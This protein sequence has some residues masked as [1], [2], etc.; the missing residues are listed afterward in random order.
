MPRR[1]RKLVRLSSIC[2]LALVALV[3]MSGMSIAARLPDKNS[4]IL[5]ASMRALERYRSTGSLSDLQSS[6]NSLGVDMSVIK[7]NE[8]VA[9]RRALIGAWARIIRTIDTS[10]D[11]KY[12]PSDANERGS[13]CLVPPREASGVQRP[14]CAD[15][16]A[17][18][19]P[20]AREKYIAELRANASKIK[21]TNF[22]Y[23]LKNIDSAAM[24]SLQMQLR[25]FR[26]AH[27]PD[28]FSALDSILRKAG[29]SDTRRAAI[30]AM[31]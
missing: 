14:S 20:E 3:M 25:G 18:Q 27:A 1:E 23:Q 2:G 13:M 11:P 21:Q 9:R 16:N 8:Y 17:I 5:A 26:N 10:Y 4:S 29:L 22:Y 15:P 6:V 24:L 31:F 12:N 19:D 30:D 28:D 7:S